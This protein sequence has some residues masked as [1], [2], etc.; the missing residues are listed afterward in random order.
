VLDLHDASRIGAKR[1][2]TVEAVRLLLQ[3]H[4]LRVVTELA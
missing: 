4:Q 3:D 2:A 1:D